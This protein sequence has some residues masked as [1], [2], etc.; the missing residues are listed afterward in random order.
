MENL[1][2]ADSNEYLDTIT[3]T[4]EILKDISKFLETLGVISDN[5]IFEVPVK[6]AYDQASKQ[7]L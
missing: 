7:W 3:L 1:R 6:V 4:P 5:K 2:L